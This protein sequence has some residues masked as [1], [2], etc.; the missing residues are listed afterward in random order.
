M[1]NETE[2][3]KDWK[4][5]MKERRKEIYIKMKAQR[6]AYLAKPEVRERMQIAKYKAKNLRKAF[7]KKIREERQRKTENKPNTSLY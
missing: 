7:M 5:I 3:K 4:A 1:E 6:K 2:P